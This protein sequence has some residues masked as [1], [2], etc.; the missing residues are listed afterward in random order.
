VAQV[1]QEHCNLER[2]ALE[3]ATDT[4]DFCGIR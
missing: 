1:G 2:L 3:D 4:G